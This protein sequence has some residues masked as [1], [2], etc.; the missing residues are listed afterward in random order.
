MT[1]VNKPPLYEL[2]QD[3]VIWKDHLRGLL[4]GHNDCGVR[5]STMLLNTFLS[6]FQKD[7]QRGKNSSTGRHPSAFFVDCAAMCHRTDKKSLKM[8]PQ[9][10]R[11]VRKEDAGE[12]YCQAKNDAGHAQCPPQM[13]E[14]CEWQAFM[15]RILKLTCKAL[16]Q[17][18]RI[19]WNDVILVTVMYARISC[20]WSC[21]STVKFFCWWANWF[22]HYVKYAEYKLNIQDNF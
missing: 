2:Q 10:F 6:P 22:D 1:N 15:C 17:F 5:K 16:M 3:Y 4:Q 11:R 12:Y 18:Q 21:W 7:C 19:F 13:M 20:N 14:V 9:K 8:S